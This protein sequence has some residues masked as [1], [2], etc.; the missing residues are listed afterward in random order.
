MYGSC[1]RICIHA[2]HIVRPPEE[3]Y[4]NLY[5]R[6]NVHCDFEYRLNAGS[7][8]HMDLQGWSRPRRTLMVRLHQRL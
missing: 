1:S 8:I 3:V 4:Q 6:F 5:H 7:S 2:V